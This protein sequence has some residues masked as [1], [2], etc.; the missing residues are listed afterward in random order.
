MLDVGRHVLALW[1]VAPQG[2]AKVLVLINVTNTP[3][4]IAVP[5]TVLSL[6]G[7]VWQDMLSSCHVVAS[8][9]TLTVTLAPY[10]VV[11]LT[12]KEDMSS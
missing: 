1:R 2:D 8:R 12:P 7:T 9:G 6:A 5:L 4:R 3:Q 10:Q 11:W